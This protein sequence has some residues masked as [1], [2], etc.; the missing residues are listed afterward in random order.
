MQISVHHHTKLVFNPL[1]DIQ[2][3]E[4]ESSCAVILS[5]INDHYLPVSLTFSDNSNG[6]VLA[7]ITVCSLSDRLR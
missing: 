4:L 7:F 1:V 3:V 5:S 6:R 2:P